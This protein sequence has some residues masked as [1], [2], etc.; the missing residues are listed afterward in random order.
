MIR[1]KVRE[2]TF[3]SESIFVN[4]DDGVAFRDRRRVFTFTFFLEPEQAAEFL[5]KLCTPRQKLARL[6]HGSTVLLLLDDELPALA[7]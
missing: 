2:E 4:I 7:P 1:P 5:A 3:E 6:L